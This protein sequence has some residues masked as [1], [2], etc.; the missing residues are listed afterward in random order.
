VKLKNGST[1]IG[2]ILL[3]TPTNFSDKGKVPE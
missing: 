1:H 3:D 2:L